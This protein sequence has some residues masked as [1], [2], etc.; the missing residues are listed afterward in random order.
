MP[1]STTAWAR[2]DAWPR[3]QCF[4]AGHSSG[5]YAW[6]ALYFVL[7]GR[8]RWAGLAIGLGLG[9]AF[10]ATQWARG[11]HFPSHDVVSAAVAWAVALGAYAGLYGKQ[12]GNADAPA[13]G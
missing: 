4:P 11:M 13:A 8:R 3:A 6:V 5:G 9:L 7:A 1:V 10:G 12:A 2:S